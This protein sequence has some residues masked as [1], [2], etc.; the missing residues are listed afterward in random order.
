MAK[1]ILSIE[2]EEH[3]QRLIKLILEKHDYSV[4]L[5]GDGEEGLEKAMKNSP[6]PN[7]ILLDI[8]MPGMDGL[9]VLRILK[10]NVETRDIPVVMLSALSHQ[11]IVLQGV[12]LG[13]KDYI[14]KPFNPNDLVEKIANIL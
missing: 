8:K 10:S 7:L 4:T 13:A 12:K 5:A 1:H 11:N 14:R 2:D 3:I 6:R 9:K